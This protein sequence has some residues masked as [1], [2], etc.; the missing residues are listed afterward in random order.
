MDE[1]QKNIIISAD[2][3]G[4]SRLASENILKLVEQGKIDRVEVMMSKNITSALAERLLASKVKIDIHLH[5]AKNELD[6]W[7]EHKRRIEDG[8]ILR[9]IKFLAKYILGVTSTKNIKKEW[10]GQIEEFIRV[11]KKAPDGASSHEHIHFFPPYFSCILDLCRKFEVGY[12]RF[13]RKSSINYSA[14]SKILNWLRKRNLNKF[15]KSK[16]DS[17]DF[18]ISFDW[19]NDLQLISSQYDKTASKEIVFH[20][21]KVNEFNVLGGFNKFN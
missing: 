16:I 18:M 8:A 19:T 7:Q 13:G 6:F 15:N 11:F 12:I 17:A 20:P 10:E 2:D 5:L 14:I 9:G 21:E 1:E 4:I 3:F